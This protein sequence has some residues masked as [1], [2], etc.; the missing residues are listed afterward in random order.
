ML[1]INMIS[2][3]GDVS[4][5]LHSFRCYRVKGAFQG[6]CKSIKL[7]DSKGTDQRQNVKTVTEIS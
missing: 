2:G 6:F 4:K 5:S 7:E 3:D 1:I